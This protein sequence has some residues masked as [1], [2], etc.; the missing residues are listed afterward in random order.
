MNGKDNLYTH[1]IGLSFNPVVKNAPFSGFSTLISYLLVKVKI[2][3]V[4]YFLNAFNKFIKDS[5]N[6][7]T[8][9]LE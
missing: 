1:F 2:N 6:C 3:L 8:L 5:S 4:E 7:K 9:A